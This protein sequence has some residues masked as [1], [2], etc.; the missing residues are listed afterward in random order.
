MLNRKEFIKRITAVTAS[1]L[2]GVGTTHGKSIFDSSFQDNPYPVFDLHCHP[3]SFYLKGTPTYE[4]DAFVIKTVNEMKSGKLSGTFISMVMDLPIL[5]REETGIVPARAFNNGEAWQ[6]YKR[7]LSILNDLFNI[8][9]AMPAK[10]FSDLTTYK[11][12]NQIAAFLACEGGDFLEAANQLDE[13]YADGV[14]SIQLVHYAPNPLGDLQTHPEQHNG[15]SKLG[16]DVVKKMNTLGMVIDVAHASQKTVTDV[17]DITQA[18]IILSHS[19]LKMESTR[20]ISS[21]AITPTHAKLVAQTGGVIGAW[22]SGFNNSFDEFVMNTLRLVDAVGINHVGLGT[23][24]DS[25]FKPVLSS[26]KQLQQWTAALKKKGLSDEEVKKLA[27]GNVE[28][29]LGKVLRST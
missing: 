24:M 21:R 14:R 23:D 27:G 9:D 17:V 22:P 5:K 7:Q 25:N 16:K 12:S 4:G 2:F 13:V 19:I 20:P 3:G 28:R 29:V 18:P 6:E 8:I 15:L 10:S 1:T 26:Y 11:N